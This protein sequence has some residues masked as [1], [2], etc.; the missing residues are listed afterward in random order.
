MCV[1]LKPWRLLYL[2]NFIYQPKTIPF[3]TVVKLK[4]IYCVFRESGSSTA[5]LQITIL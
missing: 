5:L 4:E 3:D 2:D 1:F